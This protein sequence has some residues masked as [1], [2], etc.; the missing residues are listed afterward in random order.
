MAYM[1]QEM[2]KSLE[3]RVKSILNKYGLKGSLS[4]RHHSTLVLTLLQGKINFLAN[5]NEIASKKNSRQ[6]TDGYLPVNVYWYEEMFSDKALEFFT[7][8]IPLL[9]E[10]NHDNSDAMTDYYDVGWYVDIR[11]GYWNKPYKL[12]SE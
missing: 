10:G 4:V 12:I 5:Y 6:F 1:N 3:P 2:K 11:V 8:I 9:N 7:E